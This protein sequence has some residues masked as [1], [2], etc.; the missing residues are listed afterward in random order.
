MFAGWVSRRQQEVIDYLKEENRIL[1]EQMGER[2]PRL[3]DGQ[4]RRLAVKGKA[5]GCN[6]LRE[7]A[8]I[9]TPETILRWYRKLIAQ[10]YDG[11]A[12]RGRG[13]PR[14]AQAIAALV[15][16]SPAEFWYRTGFGR[17]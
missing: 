16:S 2:R 7:T 3:T 15:W 11:S 4:R 5:L 13:R 17:R 12:V 10:K 8:C 14:T 1:R 6:L 9:V